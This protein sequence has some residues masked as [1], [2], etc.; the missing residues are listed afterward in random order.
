MATQV[1]GYDQKLSS[2]YGASIPEMV[3]YSGAHEC[4]LKCNSTTICKGFVWEQRRKCIPLSTICDSAAPTT[5]EII[6][7]KSKAIKIM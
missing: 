2:C 4:A 7:V 6:Y 5:Y 1:D 3:S